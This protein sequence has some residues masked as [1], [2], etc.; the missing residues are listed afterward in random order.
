[1]NA[2]LKKGCLLESGHTCQAHP[3]AAAVARGVGDSDRAGLG[4]SVV[5]GRSFWGD[6]IRGTSPFPGVRHP[7]GDHPA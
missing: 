7:S 5:K 4:A 3:G 2:Q 1:M 6:L